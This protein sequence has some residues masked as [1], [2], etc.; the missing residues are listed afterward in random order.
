M[1]IENPPFT[2]RNVAKF[3]VRAAVSVKAA[4]L[5]RTAIADHTPLETTDTPVVIAGS[6]VGWYVGDKVRP[7][8]DR[9]VD[10]TADFIAAKRQKRQDRKSKKTTETE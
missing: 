7:Y 3:V 2:P 9:A 8:S 10:K 5:T 6:L 4:N 1:T